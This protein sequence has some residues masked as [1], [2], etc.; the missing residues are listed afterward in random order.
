MIACFVLIGSFAWAVGEPEAEDFVPVI[1]ENVDYPISGLGWQVIT[2]V[3]ADEDY[4]IA[5]VVKNTVNPYMIGQARG[6]T[7]AGIAMGF[8]GLE[9]APAEPDSADEQ[10]QIVRDLISRGVDGIAI[11]PIDSVALVPACE[12]AMDA[13]IPVVN[14]GTALQTDNKLAHVGTPYYHTGVWIA[15]WVADKLGGVGKIVNLTGPPEAA[16]AHERNAGIHFTLDQYPDI[17][18]IAE[19]PAYFRRTDALAAMETIIERFGAENIDAVIGANDEVAM[20]ALTALEGAGVD[21]DRIIIAGFDANEDYTHALLEG[22]VDVTF[23][24]DPPSSAWLAAAY[25][26]EYLNNGTMPPDEYVIYPTVD[27]EGALVTQDNVEEYLKNAWWDA[28]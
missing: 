28:P 24:S 3:R 1:A 7:E 2:D 21:T 10:A 14:I 26:V 20:G 9:L 8:T 19:Q 13:G 22:R 18:I 12:A 25:L 17:E 16:N 4:L 6:I 11:H 15:E 27:Q 5:C 23:N